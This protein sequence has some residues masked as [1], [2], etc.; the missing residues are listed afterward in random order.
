VSALAVLVGGSAQRIVL[1]T[2]YCCVV[3]HDLVSIYRNSQLRNK[4]TCHLGSACYTRM[5]CEIRRVVC[6]GFHLE[7]QVLL[8]LFCL[9]AQILERIAVALA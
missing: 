4:C 1:L 7:T 2:T 5:S 8:C 9:Y 3:V 6:A